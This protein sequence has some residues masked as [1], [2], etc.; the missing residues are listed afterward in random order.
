[1][2]GMAWCMLRGILDC[3][4]FFEPFGRPGFLLLHAKEVF[5]SAGALVGVSLGASL[6]EE[7]DRVPESMRKPR[8]EGIEMRGWGEVEGVAAL[9]CE[10]VLEFGT[11]VFGKSSCGLEIKL[12]KVER[13]I[14]LS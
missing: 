8:E 9:D 5:T 1:M 3:F 6:E 13:E 14:F 7:K 4:L 12:L 11:N 10:S 2:E